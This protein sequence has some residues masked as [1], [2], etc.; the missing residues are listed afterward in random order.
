MK[1]NFTQHSICVSPAAG[2]S[3]TEVER[4]ETGDTK[5]LRNDRR[6]ETLDALRYPTA[7]SVGLLKHL[8][9]KKLS[10]L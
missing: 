6:C 4:R 8:Q 5:I 9:L 3:H 1:F 7:L 10:E 2:I